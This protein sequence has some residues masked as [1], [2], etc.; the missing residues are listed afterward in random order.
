MVGVI[1][2]ARMGSTRL[3][4]KT[5]MII[6]GK[7][8]LVH[9]IERLKKSNLIETIV[10]ATTDKAIDKPILSLA[11]K[12]QVEKFA[13]SEADVLDRYYRAAKKFKLDPVVRVTADCPLIDPELIDKVV[14]YYLKKKYDY[15]SMPKNYPEGLDVE[16]F[17]FRALEKAWQQASRPSEREHVT[18]YIWKNPRIFS[19]GRPKGNLKRNYS[20]LHLSVDEAK[21]LTLMRK[22]YKRLYRREKIFYLRN[23]LNLFKREP[24]LSKINAGLTGYEG[25]QKSLEQDRLAKHG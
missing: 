12:C 16:V 14:G 22:V 23:I 20:Y 9:L 4:G 11:K 3:P 6:C 18:S 15:V 17:S 2:Q 1:V 25:Y 5:M 7:P 8:M 13:G 21:D 19:L 24:H 10:I